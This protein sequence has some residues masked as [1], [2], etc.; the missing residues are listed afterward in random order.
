MVKQ[1]FGSV[2]CVPNTGIIAVEGFPILEIP[3]RH[4]P[5]KR[6]GIHNEVIDRGL[7]IFP[8]LGRGMLADGIDK[9]VGVDHRS[10]PL[11]RTLR[12]ILGGE[13]SF[14]CDTRRA[15]PDMHFHGKVVLTRGGAIPLGSFIHP[16]ASR[17]FPAALPASPNTLR[18]RFRHMPQLVFQD[19]IQRRFVREKIP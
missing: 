5:I 15:D 13:Q 6:T 4:K 19:R 16:L 14:A 18:L 17:P 3:L 9:A 1:W 12:L 10:G 8:E 2:V 11:Q 7:L